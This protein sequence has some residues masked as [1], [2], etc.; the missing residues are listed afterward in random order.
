[1]CDKSRTPRC[2]TPP[3]PPLLFPL[4]PYLFEARLERMEMGQ[5]EVTPGQVTELIIGVQ[6]RPQVKSPGDEVGWSLI[7]RSSETNKKARGIC[8]VNQ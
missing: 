8:Q 1:M 6:P 5:D 4:L 7:L 3:P 2:P